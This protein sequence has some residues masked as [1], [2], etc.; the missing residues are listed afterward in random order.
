MELSI[1]DKAILAHVV[2]DPNVWVAHA[3]K[4][5]GEASVKAKIARWRADY[6]TQKDDPSYMTRAERDACK[7]AE[8]VALEEAVAAKIAAK[9]TAISGCFPSWDKVS[10]AVDDIASLADAK[11]FLKK[12]VR[13]VYWLARDSEK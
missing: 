4:N 11:V 3:L 9:T 8:Q 12:L 5:G 2:T 10:T 7:S 13:V 6:L 1:I